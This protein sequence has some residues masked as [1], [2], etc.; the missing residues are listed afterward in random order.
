[1]VRVRKEEIK[2]ITAERHNSSCAEA[3]NIADEKIGDFCCEGDE[4]AIED[5]HDD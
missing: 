4:C 1:M 5:W 3:D 2:G